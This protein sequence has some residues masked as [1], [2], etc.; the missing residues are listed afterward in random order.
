LFKEAKQI[1]GRQGAHFE[2]VLSYDV[3]ARRSTVGYESVVEAYLQYRYRGKG[4][5][6]LSLD[7]KTSTLTLKAK[8]ACRLYGQ[9]DDCLLRFL[10]FRFLELDIGSRFNLSDLNGLAVESVDLRRCESVAFREPISL[11]NLETI[12]LRPGQCS[13]AML[14][15]LVRASRPYEIIVK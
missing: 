1:D 15:R 4:S 6:S 14:R 5:L 7:S 11:P 8:Q 3:A 12:V 9:Y 10:S 13:E 2:R